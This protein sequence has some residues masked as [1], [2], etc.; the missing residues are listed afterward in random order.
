[1]LVSTLT[2]DLAQR[3][4]TEKAIRII[5]EAG[6]DAFDLSLFPM[7][8][9][10]PSYE[11]NQPNYRET[12]QHLR[13]VAD[14]CGIVCNQSHA[15]F[16]SSTADPEETAAIFRK[17]VRAME[18]ASILGAKI[19]IVHPKQHLLYKGNEETLKQMN[20]EFYRDLI[21]YAQKF[22][23]KVAVENMWQFYEDRIN[24]STCAKPEEFVSYLDE[25]NSEW[26]VGCLDVGHTAIVNEDLPNMIHALGS[27]RLQALHVHDTDFVSDQHTLPFMSKM[28]FEAICAALADIGYEGDITLEAD[29][30]LNNVPDGLI[31]AAVKFMCETTRYLASK[32]SK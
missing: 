17:I 4:G 5:A 18:I 32:A 12:A 28:D 23:I 25:I 6:F 3:Y 30:F 21:P 27:K 19:I 1:M 11:M 20:L 22:N 15:P 16:H 14:E 9:N 31:P 29:S 2:S 10:D 8:H 24:Y 7:I 13:R 26:I